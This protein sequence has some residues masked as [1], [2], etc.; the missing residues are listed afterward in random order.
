L[1]ALSI[2]P[3]PGGGGGGIDNVGLG[4]IGIMLSV[5]G[6]DIKFG[7]DTVGISGGGGN[8]DVAVGGGGGGSAL[9]VGGIGRGSGGGGGVS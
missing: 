3:L 1:P 2:P 4:C 8:D 6:V 7:L 9:L 5:D